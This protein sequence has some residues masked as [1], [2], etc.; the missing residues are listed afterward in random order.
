LLQAELPLY[1]QVVH[2]PVE[3]GRDVV[4]LTREPDGQLLLKMYQVKVGDITTPGFEQARRQLEDMFLVPTRDFQFGFD[5]EPTREGVLICNGHVAPIVE[6]VVQG[7]FHAELRDH[8]HPYSL[9]HLDGW[10][11]WIV[12]RISFPPSDTASSNWAFIS[13]SLA[14]LNLRSLHHER[15]GLDILRALRVQ[16]FSTV[17]GR[18]S[19]ASTPSNRHTGAS[20]VD[21][22]K[23]ARSHSPNLGPPGQLSMGQARSS[24][25]SRASL[26]SPAVW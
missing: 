2:G 25:R 19:T 17:K 20:Q 15:L 13:V 1:A 5:I 10:V 26:R 11:R 21:E 9:I 12:E 14:D 4:V 23:T 18:R 7:W 22:P 8:G 3:Y 16:L 24:A 6:P